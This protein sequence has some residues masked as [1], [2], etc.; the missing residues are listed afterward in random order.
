MT[1]KVDLK[2]LLETGAHFGHQ[3]R[4]WNPK[5]KPFIYGSEGGVH[6]FDLIKTQKALEEALEILSKASSED[7]KILFVGTKKQIKEEVERIAKQT[8]TFYV[9]ERWLGG[10]L[11][12]F[13][14]MQKTIK[15]LEQMKKDREEGAYDDR[16]K[17]E[18]LLIDRKIARMERFMGGLVGLTEFPDLIVIIDINK[19]HGAAKEA[20]MKNIETIGIVDSNSDPDTVTYPI[21]MNDDATKALYYVL[22]LMGDAVMEGKKKTTKTKK[23]K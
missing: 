9:S 19:E 4:R 17:K 22:G 20:N 13:D 3:V 11:T 7:K 10:T 6:V 21:P 2:T 5:M 14:Q 23:T 8:E 18:R 12:N 16:T 1:S 15:Q